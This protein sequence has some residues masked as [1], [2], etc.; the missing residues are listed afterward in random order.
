MKMS[1]NPTKYEVLIE[2]YLCSILDISVRSLPQSRHIDISTIH[3]HLDKQANRT[4]DRSSVHIKVPYW[5]EQL[6]VIA[7]AY[8]ACLLFNVCLQRPN[9]C[10]GNDTVLL[11]SSTTSLYSLV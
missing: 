3:T 10:H 2:Q 9:S 8:I 4:L 11:Q 1:D 5:K 7:S 6:Q